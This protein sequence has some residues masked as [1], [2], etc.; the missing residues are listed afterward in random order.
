MKLEKTLAVAINGI[1]FLSAFWGTPGLGADHTQDLGHISLGA[2][3]GFDLTLS[4]A[5]KKE[6]ELDRD[7]AEIYNPSSSNFHHFITPEEFKKRY[8]LDE[9]EI[10]ETVNYLEQHG[11][12]SVVVAANG[13]T[14]SAVGPN[15][16]VQRT[17]NA[18]IHQYKD[19]KGRLFYAPVAR[20]AIPHDLHVEA[21]YGLD[22]SVRLHPHY[23][24]DMSVFPNPQP[25]DQ[26]AI[27]G[28]S[29][30]ALRKAYNFPE[31]LRG[32][33]QVLALVEMD[34]YNPNDILE[35]EN[36]YGLPKVPLRNI[37]LDVSGDAGYQAVE[38]VLDIEMMAAIAPDAKS[39]DVY[40]GENSESGILQIF[41][42]IANDNTAKAISTSWGTA[43]EHLS[44]EFIKD[45]NRILKQMAMQ[46][47]AVFAAA[48]D[49][50]SNDNGYSATV[51]DPAAEP[52]VTGVGG[53]HLDIDQD[54]NYSGEKAWT[55]GGGGVSSL[56]PIPAYQVPIAK[57]FTKLS[58]TQRNVPDVSLVADITPGF[59]MYYNSA[60]MV[61]GGTSGA[62]PL[63][64]AFEA[65]VNE[66]R[67]ENNLSVLG[68][69][70]S[71]LYAV[72]EGSR[73]AFDFHDIKEG[74]NGGYPACE[75]P[76]NSSGL[77]TLNADELLRDLGKDQKTD[78]VN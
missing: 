21:V 51:D 3:K 73:Y 28:F 49:N 34:G 69:A 50:G 53:T 77:G 57:K 7:L 30:H 60:W 44:A 10:A 64:A 74:S 78:L 32:K 36:H 5:L 25:S 55:S 38:V 43:E 42:K 59:S 20:I 52:Y 66:R 70:N 75:G 68:F 24:S 54:G 46:G 41:S 31:S 76:D 27:R 61:E 17:F 47:Q 71:A 2:N 63:W 33:D 13:L 6:E 45:E 9:Q 16:S 40:E 26:P 65:L 14:I 4:L 12:H 23:M 19:S 39:I 22:N 1:L 58:S 62:A 48:G 29:P 15:Q 8:A 18:D 56:W 72:A 35:Y 11:F 37:L 67:Q